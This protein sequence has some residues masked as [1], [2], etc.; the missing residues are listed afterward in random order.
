MSP[1]YSAE[2]QS[3]RNEI[4]DLK[5]IILNLQSVVVSKNLAQPGNIMVNYAQ[6]DNIQTE[7]PN[8]NL[9]A[10]GGVTVE[11]RCPLIPE[12]NTEQNEAFIRGVESTKWVYVTKLHPNTSEDDVVN[13]VTSKLVISKDKIKC[14]KL[15]TAD[16]D[17]SK[18]DFV[19]FKILVQSP[20]YVELLHNKFWPKNVTSREFQN[21]QNFRL[22]HR[23][24]NH[25]INQ[26]TTST[27]TTKM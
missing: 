20:K 13:Y 25:K 23:R 1:N 14:S 5:T 17:L 2:I 10:A 7:S 21:R 6:H 12:N 11:Q 27:F 4:A 15:V 18:M 22:G 3:L 9:E 24:S 16:S 19:S 8:Q 26:P